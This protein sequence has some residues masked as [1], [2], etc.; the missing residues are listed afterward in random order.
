MLYRKLIAVYSQIHIKYTI[1]VYG[2]NVYFLNVKTGGTH[3][4]HYRLFC[5]RFIR[6]RS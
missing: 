6:A 3:T 4:V 1:T 5:L 2:Q